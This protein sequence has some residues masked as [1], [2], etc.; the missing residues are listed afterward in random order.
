[1]S[2]IDE[3]H[4]GLGHHGGNHENVLQRFRDLLAMHKKGTQPSSPQEHAAT[5]GVL[6]HLQLAGH[7]AEARELDQAFKFSNSDPSW[8]EAFSKWIEDGHQLSSAYEKHTHV[9]L[10]QSFVYPLPEGC[11]MGIIGD[12]GTG[13]QQSI[14]LAEQMVSVLHP[15]IFI[16]LG[17]V[18][19]AGTSGQFDKFY[20]QPLLRAFHKQQAS[21]LRGIVWTL[22]GN[23]DYYGG[24]VP[25][26]ECLNKIGSHQGP[27][28]ALVNN[29]W[30]VIGLDTALH[31]SNPEETARGIKDTFMPDAQLVW[32]KQQID[33]AK[34]EGKGVIV[35]SHH[36][37]FSSHET[38]GEHASLSY[39][40]E[41]L[42]AEFGQEYISKI[43][44]W[45]WGH[46]HAW[47]RYGPYRG[48][49]RGYLLGNGGIPVLPKD[50]PYDTKPVPGQQAPVALSTQPQLF[51]IE[52]VQV[53]C[54][55]L[56]RLEFEGPTL[57]IQYYELH[58]H[59][60]GWSLDAVPGERQSFVN[61][62]G[63]VGE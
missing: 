10:G 37:L 29:H 18:Y 14:I 4:P 58:Q 21:D 27:Y 63:V 59:E 39:T 30:V 62:N 41:K 60:N 8:F 28:F 11:S 24:G 33:A 46:E 13:N 51:S 16:H 25:F 44:L 38:T 47:T 31:D 17:D 52:G 1:M 2:R 9:A 48:L 42:Y 53:F 36:M 7:H 40:N 49:S 45:F 5:L 6:L 20:I 32:A 35:L 56:Y 12:W 22:P 57:H 43:D 61:K 23:H 50:K 26:F 3:Q 55:G 19:Y 15:D 54:N 34:R